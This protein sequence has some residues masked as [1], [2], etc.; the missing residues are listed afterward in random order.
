MQLPY[1]IISSVERNTINVLPHGNAKRE[2]GRPYRR[3]MQSTREA[4]QDSTKGRETAKSV[5]DKVYCSVGDVIQ[6]RSVG[7]LPRGPRDIYNARSAAKKDTVNAGRTSHV[8]DPTGVEG[9]WELLEKAK[10]EEKED[11]D[12]MFIRECRI[13]PDFLVVLA[14]NRQLQDLKNFCTDPN[15]FCIFGADPTFN[16]FQESI[17]L[18]VT[19]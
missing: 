3:Q 12:S 6:A 13:H 11:N 18:T 9:I 8:K 1:T 10:R 2:E 19:T 5:L 7:E 16:I 14:S 17:S 15:D 4:L